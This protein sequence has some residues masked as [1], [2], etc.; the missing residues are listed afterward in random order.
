MR[1][2]HYHETLATSRQYK[3]YAL[4][5]IGEP[6]L[7]FTI[8]PE[9][10]QIEHIVVGLSRIIEPQD[11]RL[12]QDPAQAVKRNDA[13]VGDG[14][15]PGRDPAVFELFWK[16]RPRPHVLRR[17]QLREH[18]RPGATRECQ[19]VRSSLRGKKS[20]LILSGRVHLEGL[21]IGRREQPRG[22]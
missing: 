4:L 8:N 2:L 10:E 21:D 22:V 17:D 18:N 16:W 15:I 20:A 7:P 1:S 9:F 19:C 12:R 13:I 14:A 11:F 3:Q 5:V 6:S